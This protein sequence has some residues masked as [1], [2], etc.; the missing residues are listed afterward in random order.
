MQ[1]QFSFFYPLRYIYINNKHKLHHDYKSYMKI[2]VITL[3]T[4]YWGNLPSLPCK[5]EMFPFEK[6][7]P[8]YDRITLKT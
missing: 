5:R 8:N 7:R 4:K 1:P 6:N 2:S 3:G